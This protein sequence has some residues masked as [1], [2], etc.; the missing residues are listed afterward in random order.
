MIK[1]LRATQPT[2]H[3]AVPSATTVEAEATEQNDTFEVRTENPFVDG[4]F[5]F[6]PRAR[7]EASPPASAPTEVAPSDVSIAT[8]VTWTVDDPGGTAA[9]L[10]S[11]TGVNGELQVAD[12][13]GGFVFT[14]PDY[15]N[16]LIFTDHDSRHV[17]F[18]VSN[19]KAFVPQASIGAGS[20]SVVAANYGGTSGRSNTWSVFSRIDALQVR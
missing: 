7:P 6:R 16:R 5:S 13:S 19:G 9:S 3:V 14:M 1:T 12:V 10:A 11:S 4:R 17:I 18:E 2:S 8:M 15:V 20:Y